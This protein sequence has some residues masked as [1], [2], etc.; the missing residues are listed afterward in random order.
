MKKR[1]H[2]YVWRNYLKPWATNKKIWCYREGK[3]FNPNVMGIGQK[4]DFYKLNELTDKDIFIINKYII[5]PS[6]SH[7]HESSKTWL[8][9]FSWVH[10]VKNSLSERDNK[11]INSYINDLIHNFEE[12]IHEKIESNGRK[13]LDS[14][15]KEDLSFFETKN[16]CVN[17]SHFLSVQ[18]LRTERVK[19]KIIHGMNIMENKNPE[20]RAEIIWNVISHIFATNISFNIYAST[21]SESPFRIILLKNNGNN[22]FITGDQ[23]VINIY[24]NP[25]TFEDPKD[26]E[27]Y[28]PVSPKLSILLTKNKYYR[29]EK[30]IE[31]SDGQ[32]KYY[33]RMIVQNSKNQIY[34]STREALA[35]EFTAC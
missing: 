21:I 35:E 10:K 16:G 6:D 20:F 18:L 4:R 24:N 27:L 23:P 14:I 31:I 3:V 13:Y 29:K 12:N 11:N 8:E 15:L 19:S 33:N 32:V 30:R 25:N 28:Y 1:R 2:H 5:E 17:F 9:L 26:T 7:L 34:A 22:E